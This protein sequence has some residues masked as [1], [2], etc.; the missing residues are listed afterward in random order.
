MLRIVG[1]NAAYREPPSARGWVMRNG[2]KCRDEE[3][4]VPTQCG[5]PRKDS[6]LGYSS[7][8][9]P[10][11]KDH[12]GPKLTPKLPGEASDSVSR[13]RTPT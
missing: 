8:W 6:R 3:A 7:S 1:F 4:R 13:A 11:G 12:R 5:A 10:T 9:R 2:G